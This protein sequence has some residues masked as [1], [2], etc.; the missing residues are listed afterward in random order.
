VV[1]ALLT[2]LFPLCFAYHFSWC[3]HWCT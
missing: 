2:F 1:G 3:I